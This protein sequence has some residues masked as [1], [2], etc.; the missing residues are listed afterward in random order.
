MSLAVGNW[1]VTLFACY[2]PRH[3]H[4]RR[5][6]VCPDIV[7]HR[8]NIYH[9]CK[10]ITIMTSLS[11]TSSSCCRASHY[12]AQIRRHHTHTVWDTCLVALRQY[13]LSLSTRERRN[14]DCM[15]WNKYTYTEVKNHMHNAI[16]WLDWLHANIPNSMHVQLHCNY[17]QQQLYAV[18]ACVR[19]WTGYLSFLAV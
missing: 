3:C 9:M 4:T 7:L 12:T 8:I 2:T 17:L 19:A 1:T 15:L 5:T 13:E 6:T 14:N 10:L 16:V 18:C 11:M